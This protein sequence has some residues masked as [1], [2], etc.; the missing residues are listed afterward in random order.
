MRS[1]LPVPEHTIVRPR[2][3]NDPQIIIANTF[4][5]V[6][7]VVG[8]L[9]EKVVGPGQGKR[10]TTEYQAPRPVHKKNRLLPLMI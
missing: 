8:M 6:E 3:H 9:H 2:A 10:R 1:L 4:N 5:A 7:R